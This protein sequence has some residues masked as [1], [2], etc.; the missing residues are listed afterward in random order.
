[1][2]ESKTARM[3]AYAAFASV[4]LVLVAFLV[5]TRSGM[6]DSNDPAAKIASYYTQHRSAAL[7][8]QFFFGLSFLTMAVF[9]A[10]VVVMMWRAP[11][12]RMLAVVAAVGGAAAGGTAL[13]GSAMMTVLAYRPPVGDPGLMRALLDSGYI[14]LNASVFVFAAFIGATAV[15]SMRMQVF[16]RWVGDVGLAAA[17]LQVVGAAA[18]SRGDGAFSPQGLVPLIAILSFLVWAVCMGT[19]LVRTQ[20]VVTAAPSAPA[21]AGD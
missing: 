13:V 3:T 12:A 10:G 15:A 14:T 7:A 1:M 6:P 16:P 21:P 9:I 11:A 2:S 8:Q 19:A 20:E 4:V 18:Y 5:F 17:V